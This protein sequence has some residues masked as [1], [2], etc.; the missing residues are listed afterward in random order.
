MR[1]IIFNSD[2]DLIQITFQLYISEDHENMK[3]QSMIELSCSLKTLKVKSEIN[4]IKSKKISQAQFT[5]KKQ[6]KSNLLI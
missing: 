6:I 3:N 4:E 2:D 1:I 5:K